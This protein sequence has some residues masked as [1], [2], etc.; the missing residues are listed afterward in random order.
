MVRRRHTFLRSIS[1]SLQLQK[2][3]P[4]AQTPDPNMNSSF[5]TFARFLHLMKWDLIITIKLVKMKFRVESY[6]LL[7][8]GKPRLH[9]LN[10]CS[11]HFK[12]F[13]KRVSIVSFYIEIQLIYVLVSGVWQSNYKKC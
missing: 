11:Q 3:N 8:L 2:S 7:S 6:K 4:N 13:R 12:K 1:K 5:G 10:A 9:V